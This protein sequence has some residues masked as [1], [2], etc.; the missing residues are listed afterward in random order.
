MRKLIGLIVVAWSL[1]ATGISDT[2]TVQA[3]L[4]EPGWDAADATA[5]LQ[6]AID[7][8]ADTVVVADMGSEWMVKP[9]A[10]TRNDQTL[11]FEEGVVVYASEDEFKGR[12]DCLLTISGRSNVTV[13]GYGATLRMR[14]LDYQDESR[15]EPAE[16]RHCLSIVGGNNI[17]VFGLR[18]ES[19][20]GDGVFVG[21][22]NV[23]QNILLG[24]LICDDNHRQGISVTNVSGLIVRDCAF[25]NTWGTLPQCGIDIEPDHPEHVIRD[26]QLINCAFLRNRRYG[27][28]VT[29]WHSD[30]STEDFSVAFRRCFSEAY[31]DPESDNEHG[32][33]KMS[34][35]P[36][37]APTGRLVFE[38]C[39][40]M[41]SLD[42]SDD[43]A[44]W[45]QNL[46]AYDILGFTDCLWDNSFTAPIKFGNSSARYWSRAAG[47]G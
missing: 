32:P 4:T 25:M 7:S 45:I 1:M 3:H 30:A 13:V 33:L 35:H 29:F 24:D 21:G 12:G 5:C 2:L 8:G 10:M 16:W 15:Y 37:S 38:Q 44:T 23:S 18:L 47:R 46:P 26:V 34:F 41:G 22:G 6:A 11:I 9:V 20:G 42:P 31:G 36:N 40:F 19:S 43:R 28:K 27:I 17:S 39:D 14:K